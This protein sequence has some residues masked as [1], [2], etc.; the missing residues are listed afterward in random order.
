MSP[1]EDSSG[2]P[3]RVFRCPNCNE[4]IN[5][6]LKHCRFCGWPVDPTVAEAAVKIQQRVNKV[7]NDASYAKILAEAMPIVYALAW[8]NIV[9]RWAYAALFVVVPFLAVRSWWTIKSVGKSDRDLQ[10]AK[11]SLRVA[12]R[13]WP[14]MLV[15]VMIGFIILLKWSQH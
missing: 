8:I 6:A 5:T 3:I 10:R 12:L 7:C 11:R 9:G 1:S 2:R 14:V 15:V 4:F 13:I